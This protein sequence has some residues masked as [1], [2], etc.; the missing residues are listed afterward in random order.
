MPSFL[1]T[2]PYRP[3][4]LAVAA[5]VASALRSPSSTG[6]TAEV[7]RSEAAADAG[8]GRGDV[9]ASLR[10]LVSDSQRTAAGYRPLPAPTPV[11]PPPSPEAVAKIMASA[12]V[13]RVQ[14][15]TDAAK[16]KDAEAVAAAKEKKEPAAAGAR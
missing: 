9:A 7:R 12:S 15:A 1:N 13:V 11:P 6:V 4:S 5:V 8:K 10:R 2:A 14:A 16:V 3:H